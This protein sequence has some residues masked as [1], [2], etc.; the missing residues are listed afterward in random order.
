MSTPSNSIS[1]PDQQRDLMQR[2]NF[3]LVGDVIRVANPRSVH[4]DIAAV[5]T[6]ITRLRLY[7][8]SPT[9]RDSW[10]YHWDAIMIGRNGSIVNDREEFPEWM[11]ILLRERGDAVVD[12][13][14]TYRGDVPRMRRM[15]RNFMYYVRDELRDMILEDMLNDDIYIGND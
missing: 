4:Y 13:I 12:V 3:F 14:A 6:Q 8:T 7:F 2:R 10:C 5:V 9:N 11:N 1:W 15:F